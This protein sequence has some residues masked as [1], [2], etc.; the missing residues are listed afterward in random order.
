MVSLH[1]SLRCDYCAKGDSWKHRKHIRWLDASIY[2]SSA[3][4]AIRVEHDW[5]ALLPKIENC[6]RIRSVRYSKRT[7]TVI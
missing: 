1:P 6:D 7:L 5:S 4:R 3:A 2:R